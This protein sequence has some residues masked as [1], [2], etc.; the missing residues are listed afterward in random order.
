MSLPREAI[1]VASQEKSNLSLCRPLN[2][3]SRPNKVFHVGKLVSKVKKLV[4]RNI[5][6]R[7]LVLGL[8][9]H[10]TEGKKWFSALR[11]LPTTRANRSDWFRSE[12]Q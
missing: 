3:G 8:P 5:N 10:V 12:P 1:H 6:G 4:Y 11:S 2:S 7:V 9:K